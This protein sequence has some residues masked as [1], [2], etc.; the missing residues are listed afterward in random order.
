M[1]CMNCNHDLSECDCPD[2][3]Q[4]LREAQ[5]SPHIYIPDCL[6][7]G[8][9]RPLCRCTEPAAPRKERGKQP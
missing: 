5:T 8:K 1:W 2:L 7:C 6:K 9:P 4:R 3:E